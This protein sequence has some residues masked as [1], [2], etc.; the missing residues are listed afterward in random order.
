[1]TT[2]QL[3][4]YLIDNNLRFAS[5]DEPGYFVQFINENGERTNTWVT[6]GEDRIERFNQYWSDKQ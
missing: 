6:D 4:Q 3:Y 5:L 1:M 2:E